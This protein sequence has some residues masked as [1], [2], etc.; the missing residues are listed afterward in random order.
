MIELLLVDS[1]KLVGPPTLSIL[2]MNTSEDIKDGGG[3]YGDRG[4]Q[5]VRP[6]SI[7]GGNPGDIGG[8]GQGE[9]DSEE[10]AQPVAGEDGDEDR[11]LRRQYNHGLLGG[12]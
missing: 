12:G 7:F 2:D 5:C 8:H 11:L 1:I 3:P 10:E 6:F 9:E 4:G